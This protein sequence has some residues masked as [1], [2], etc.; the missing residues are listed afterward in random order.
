MGSF[1]KGGA[2]KPVAEEFGSVYENAIKALTESMGQKQNRLWN[3]GVSCAGKI[4]TQAQTST[5]H[6]DFRKATQ[7]NG[8]RRATILARRWF[9]ESV[10]WSK[11]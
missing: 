7:K 4:S 2:S 8:L 11:N 5:K 9:C 1:F 3:A 6:L 10:N